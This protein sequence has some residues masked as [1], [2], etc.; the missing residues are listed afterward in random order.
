M[1][2]FSATLAPVSVS[3]NQ[4]NVTIGHTKVLKR[5]FFIDIYFYCYA[6]LI[7]G[8]VSDYQANRTEWLIGQEPYLEAHGLLKERARFSDFYQR[9]RQS[10]LPEWNTW[11]F[12]EEN[13]CHSSLKLLLWWFFVWGWGGD[14]ICKLRSIFILT[15]VEVVSFLFICHFFCV[16]CFFVFAV[17]SHYVI[18]TV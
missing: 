8:F 13:T 7:L 5:W 3:A 2:P 12:S 6:V 18:P 10:F 4:V 16:F 9:P 15:W 17:R 11:Q 1:A 14:I